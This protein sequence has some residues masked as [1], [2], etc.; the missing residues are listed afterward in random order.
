MIKPFDRTPKPPE[1]EHPFY[2][3]DAPLHEAGPGT[4]PRFVLTC[5]ACSTTW[6]GG[7]AMAIMLRSL[8]NKLREVERAAMAGQS[9]GQQALER[10]QR[11]LKRLG[12]QV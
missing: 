9:N 4:T 1:C 7:H 12:G 2:Q 3:L 8:Q 10:V 11:V 6:T 5:Q